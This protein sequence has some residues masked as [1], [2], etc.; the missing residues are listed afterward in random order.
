[1]NSAIEV[2]AV[3]SITTNSDWS[4]WLRQ[5][6]AILKIDIRKNF[7]GRRAL[8]LYL[9]AALPVVLMFGISVVW[10]DGSNDI[11]TKWASAQEAFGYIYGA[12][13]LRTVVFFG[14]AWIFMN[15]FRGEI[16]DKSLHYYFLCALRR[17]VLVAGKYFSGLVATVILFTLTTAGS[18]FFLYYARGYPANMNYI[19]DG[20]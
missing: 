20:P 18:L 14:C 8:L 17:E 19:F 6:R 7:W 9:L 4:L 5:I 3:K 15:L 10:T 13:I 1:M 2:E 12:L 16:V 11:R